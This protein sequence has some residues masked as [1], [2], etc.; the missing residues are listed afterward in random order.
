MQIGLQTFTVRKILTPDTLS[1]IFA[2]IAALGIENLELA[3]DYLPM[4]FTLETAKAVRAAAE[5]SHLRIC[6]CQIKYATS[7]ANI[8]LTAA[9]MHTL[10]AKILTNSVIDLKALA[11]GK[12][13]LLRYCEKLGWLKEKLA[14]QGVTL[15]HHNHN[16]EFKRIGSQSALLFMA[17]NSTLDF[18]LDTYWT[19]RARG[20]ILALLK[21]LHGRVPLMHLRDFAGKG[22]C[23]VG[24]GEIDF[25]QVLRAAQAAGVQYGMIEQRTQTPLESVEISLWGIHHAI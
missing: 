15:A 4:P 13:A 17:E 19:Q 9:Y 8:D 22:D 18:V 7:S 10:D 20:D 1:D 24:Q 16:Y 12:G 21:A 5:K 11:L 2:K 23:E 14:A 6:S 25:A 3:V